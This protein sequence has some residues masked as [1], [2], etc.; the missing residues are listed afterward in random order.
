MPGVPGR[1][2][3][4]EGQELKFLQLNLGRR[5]DA[6]DLLKQTARE[7]G[8]MYCSL[9]SSKNGLK[10]LLGTR[11]HQGGPASLFEALISASGIFWSPTR[12]SFGWR[13]R[14]CVCTRLD[15]RAI[16]VGKMVARNDLIV[17]NQGNEF[18]CR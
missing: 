2:P 8:P 16:L 7:R 15:R 10:I 18:T 11:M 17:L 4:V 13:W 12:G 6:Q 14:V 9:T 5:K 1:T 3:E